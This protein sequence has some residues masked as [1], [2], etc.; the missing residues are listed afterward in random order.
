MIIDKN[1]PGWS[2]PDKLLYLAKQASNVP[3]AGWIVEVGTFFGRSAYAL[4][5]NKPESC[6]LTV[7][8]PFPNIEKD[9]T[10]GYGQEGVVFEYHTVLHYTKDIKN[11]EIFRGHSPMLFSNL[12]MEPINK[13]NLLFIDGSH[14]YECVKADL[15]FWG[16]MVAE[17]GII[18]C[19]D[20]YIREGVKKATDEYA[21]KHDLIFD[22]MEPTAHVKNNLFVSLKKA[23]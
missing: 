11:L 8:D 22:I 7:I 16:P 2:H 17:D 3:A 19:D 4:G 14:T 23:V 12:K 5:M 9:R 20:Y 6:L 1:I 18:I 10:Y 13:I 15:E 21:E